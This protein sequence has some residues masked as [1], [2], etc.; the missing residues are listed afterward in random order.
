MSPARCPNQT[1]ICSECGL[2][3]PHKL[4]EMIIKRNLP[5][6]IQKQSA[7][8]AQFYKTLSASLQ[9]SKF[10]SLEDF[11][12]SRL[13]EATEEKRKQL[14]A[15]Y[16]QIK[17]ILK[18]AIFGFIDEVSATHKASIHSAF[19]EENQSFRHFKQSLKIFQEK[20]E[21]IKKKLAE[22][23]QNFVEM[24]LDLQTLRGSR[25]G[26]KNADE[27]LKQ[28]AVDCCSLPLD[29]ELRLNQ[30]SQL[31]EFKNINPNE[32]LFAEHSRRAYDL[33]DIGSPEVRSVK[34][35]KRDTN[36]LLHPSDSEEDVDFMDN[37]GKL[38]KRS[39]VLLRDEDYA[40][41][42]GRTAPNKGIQRSHL[43]I[44]TSDVGLNSPRR[45]STIQRQGNNDLR[46]SRSKMTPFGSRR[47]TIQQSFQ[48]MTAN[49]AQNFV[50]QELSGKN[51]PYQT[52]I[53]N[54][55]AYREDSDKVDAFASVVTNK[56]LPLPATPIQAQAVHRYPKQG[57]STRLF[58]LADGTALVE[59]H[60]INELRMRDAF[61]Q[62]LDVH[63]QLERIEFRK[64]VFFA[65]PLS[66][67]RSLLVQPLA[68]ALLI[69]ISDN[70][71]SPSKIPK[72]EDA[73]GLQHLNVV[74][75]LDK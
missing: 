42:K 4:H 37:P 12:V 60:S 59:N 49:S 24:F 27:F 34:K 26:L 67:L 11:C 41:Q 1:E 58:R 54:L 33:M 21:Q 8:L 22:K 13:K 43:E 45:V 52:L 38:A 64:N 36:L 70:K 29:V 68:H 3:G 47:V 62:M 73:I 61:K 69:D 63:P 50:V 75:K 65:D 17:A 56:L 55:H 30:I 19:G 39:S 44:N 6:L 32:E 15:I 9:A 7:E 10:G 16:T 25:S 57:L 2:F 71:F 40:T 66:V 35:P 48:T 28:V 46:Q 5:E 23:S 18:Q 72:N 20:L 53:N 74:V 31:F 14:G 51:I